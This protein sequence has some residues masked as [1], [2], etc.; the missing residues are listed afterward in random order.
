[1]GER[2]K[3]REK[4]RKSWMGGR[5]EAGRW[6]NNM[7]MTI[8]T[9]EETGDE[10]YSD[11]D[12]DSDSDCG[13]TKTDKQTKDEITT[14][15]EEAPN[16]DINVIKNK[17]ITSD[18][19]PTTKVATSNN[20]TPTENTKELKN[21]KNTKDKYMTTERM[22]TNDKPNLS[23]DINVIEKKI[24]T[25]KESPATE[26]TTRGDGNPMAKN[27]KRIEDKKIMI[28]NNKSGQRR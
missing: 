9:I 17:I 1:M 5:G 6:K 23:V 25:S 20:E 19:S 27:V 16:D 3:G 11:S 14:T 10:K 26:V 22:A 24:S 13:T 21:K 15:N 7:I 8:G 18:K 4:E 28:D 2:L 12:S